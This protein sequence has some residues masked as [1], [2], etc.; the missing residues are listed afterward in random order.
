MALAN[1]INTDRDALIC[2]LAE[3]YGIFDYRSL[4]AQTVAALSIG[5]R[6]NSRIKMKLA[7]MEFEPDVYL[8][9]A[10]VDRLSILLWRQTKDGVEGINPPELILGHSEEKVSKGFSC[11]EEF[12]KFRASILR[13][14]G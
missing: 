9:A 13:G 14:E 3:T 8:L 7:G 5:L 12:E 11:G 10:I 4:P 6:A 1:M 2:D